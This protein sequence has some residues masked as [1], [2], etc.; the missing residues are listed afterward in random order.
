VGG[1][2]F[3]AGIVWA[4]VAGLRLVVRVLE[5]VLL[6]APTRL[7]L[8]LLAFLIAA[9]LLLLLLLLAT[10]ATLLMLLLPFIRHAFIPLNLERR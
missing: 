6:A 3:K 10:L 2:I 9:S 8:Q 4:A 5:L 7:R 1:H